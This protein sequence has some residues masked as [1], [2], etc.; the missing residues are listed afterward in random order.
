M[1]VY[2]TGKI[3][4]KSWSGDYVASLLYT[5]NQST[6]AYVWVEL[7]F[8][9]VE[10]WATP[11]RCQFNCSRFFYL[12]LEPL[13]HS[14]NTTD[15]LSNKAITFGSVCTK[16]DELCIAH[17]QTLVLSII[18]DSLWNT[19]WYNFSHWVYTRLICH[20]IF[21]W[22]DALATACTKYDVYR[23]IFNVLIMHGKWY[24]KVRHLAC[25]MWY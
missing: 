1:W 9:F 18:W 13:I 12:P 23:I 22:L 3:T 21:H 24:V 10:N 6:A 14:H 19:G 25:E 8:W 4:R 16:V 7:Q 5:V 2:I 17:M 15:G 11:I 20:I